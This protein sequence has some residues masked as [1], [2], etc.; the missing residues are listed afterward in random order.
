MVIN[1]YFLGHFSPFR[2]KTIRLVTRE[3]SFIFFEGQIGNF[4]RF[5]PKILRLPAPK[6]TIWGWGE[7]GR[8]RLLGRLKGI[9]V[10][11]YYKSDHLSKS[12][13]KI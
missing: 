9:L 12:P 7:S 13:L 5:R 3:A 8:E 10:F 2:Q 11:F 4:L 6:E 1:F